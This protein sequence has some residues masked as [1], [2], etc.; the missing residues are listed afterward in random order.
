M[1]II[2]LDFDG[3]LNSHNW[4]LANRDFIQNTQSFME[5]HARELD[6]SAVRMVSNLAQETDADVVISSSWRIFNS[7]EDMNIMLIQ[8]GWAARLPFD[9]TPNLNRGMRGNEIIEW[10]A[11]R[12]SELNVESHVIFDDDGDFH[13]GQ[14]LVRTNFETGIQQAHIDIAREILLGN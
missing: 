14:P 1:R 7:L 5:R 2:F 6:S 3:V 9:V 13:S 10:L 12:G 11:N 8:N 4:F